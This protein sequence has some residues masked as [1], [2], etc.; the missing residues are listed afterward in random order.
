MWLN[1][2]WQT[3]WPTDTFF[4][5]ASA[6]EWSEMGVFCSGWSE[7][8]TNVSDNA[9]YVFIVN[10]IRLDGLNLLCLLLHYLIPLRLQIL[11]KNYFDNTIL[12]ILMINTF[13][14]YMCQSKAYSHCV[15]DISDSG[16]DVA[17]TSDL[18]VHTTKCSVAATWDVKHA[19]SIERMTLT[20][21]W[22]FIHT[23]LNV[24]FCSLLLKEISELKLY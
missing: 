1:R 16:R 17:R 23:N 10:Y 8:T 19:R 4:V 3:R 20:F 14:L 6:S 15:A 2:V 13:V 12:D 21:K 11:L 18:S 5:T 22:F 24:F 9:P 7:E